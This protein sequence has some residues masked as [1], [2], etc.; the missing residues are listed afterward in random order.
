MDVDEPDDVI[1]EKD[2]S[3]L[4]ENDNIDMGYD[5]ACNFLK[6]AKVDSV[7]AGF[8]EVFGEKKGVEVSFGST[9]QV[10]D[11]KPPPVAA[12]KKTPPPGVAKKPK[13]PSSRQESVESTEG[14]STR[15]T[16]VKSPPPQVG[17]KPSKTFQTS[18]RTSSLDK[19]GAKSPPPKVGKKPSGISRGSSKDI[20]DDERVVPGKAQTTEQSPKRGITKSPRGILTFN[21]VYLSICLIF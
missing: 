21:L 6:L 15:R 13:S 12:K 11:K 8:Y 2:G 16:G 14:G 4:H 18:S 19:D 3:M 9:V 20:I 10:G 17:K 1:W 5:G 7:D